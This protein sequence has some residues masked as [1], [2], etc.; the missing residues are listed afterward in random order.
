MKST[1]LL[2]LAFALTVAASASAQVYTQT[3]EL[4]NNRVAE[5]LT[6]NDGSFAKPRYYA[7][8]GAG[9]GAGLGTQGAITLS[10]DHRYLFAVNAGSNSI[11]TF[12]I[13]DRG[14]KLISVTPSGGTTPVGVTSFNNLV[15]VVNAG[16]GNIAGYR[17]SSL[18]LSPIAGSI[19]PLSTDGVAPGQISF[20]PEGDTLYVTEKNTKRITTYGVSTYGVA[21]APAWV[22]SA[23]VTPF[24]FA[25]GRRGKL[26]I[27]EAFGGASLGSAISTYLTDDAGTPKVVSPSVPTFQTAACWV[28]FSP[29]ARFAYAAN[30]GSES[31]T[32]Y[33]VFTDGTV[34]LL[35]SD[36]ITGKLVVGG[37]ATDLGSDAN[38]RLF[39]LSPRRGT[40][41]VFGIQQNGGLRNEGIIAGLPTTITG[42]AIR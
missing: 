1:H 15:Y 8:G 6:R 10:S 26:V 20:N 38:G 30:A 3:N 5:I 27:S 2:T 4:G 29:D 11:S 42:I 7:T 25:F 9:T 21:S 31:V 41:N 33:R 17:L 39:V 13:G 28:A 37:G 24:G 34:S 14:I 22:E 40:L 32:G 35:N 23:G 36:G 18:G 16:S 19:Q 12:A